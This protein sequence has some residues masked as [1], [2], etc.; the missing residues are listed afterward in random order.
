MSPAAETSHT[1]VRRT[2][3]PAVVVIGR[4][5]VAAWWA[6]DAPRLGASLA[7]CTLFAIAPMWLVATA[8]AGIVFGTDAVHTELA[9]HLAAL[10]GHDG[11]E[12]VGD[13]VDTIGQRPAGIGA[14][15]LGTITFVIAATGAF[16]ELQHA[17]NTIWHVPPRSGHVFRVFL[18]D[19]VRSV[20]LVLAVGSLLIVSLATT[21]VSAAV[22]GWLAMQGTVASLAW[23]GWGTLA[24]VVA[25]MG[26]V[27]LLFGILPDVHV[28]AR[29]V[30]VGAVLTAVLLTVGHAFMGRYLGQNIVASSYGVAGAMLALLLWVYYSCEIL[31][32]GAE[33]T[34][35]CAEY[36]TPTSVAA[37]PARD[38]VTPCR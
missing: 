17:L 24:S 2:R 30:S 4:S 31:L 14:T 32:F 13:L 18:R 29:D 3:L 21:G 1:G 5:A 7:Y 26:L 34:R 12:V 15:V 6:D 11:A 20:G 35:A 8:A 33:F 19:R 25:T 36:R 27:A 22:H 28:S 23:T 9:A 16:I 38:P 10:V 37:H